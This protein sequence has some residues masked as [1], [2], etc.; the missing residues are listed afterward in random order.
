M[1]NF[2]NISV[3]QRN[4]LLS[5]GIPG[6]VAL[7]AW[8]SWVMMQG[9]EPRLAVQRSFDQVEVRWQCDDGFEFNAP[10]A[11]GP[12]PCPNG[13]GEAYVVARYRCSE[14]GEMNARLRHE[15]RDDGIPVLIAV[16]FSEG[17]WIPVDHQQEPACPYCGRE[18]QRVLPDVFAKARDKGR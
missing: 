2:V 13:D 18:M 16:S 14:H 8:F 9:E 10:G 11:L 6:A 12:Q 4:W 1:P 7:V 3:Q 17:Q 15:L 5:L